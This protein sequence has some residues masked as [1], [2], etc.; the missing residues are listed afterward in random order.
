MVEAE[1]VEEGRLEVVH[2][3]GIL[4]DVEAHLVG[5]AEGHAGLDAAA[6]QPHRERLGVV[7]PAEAPA[8]CRIGLDHG[9][10]AELTAPDHQRVVEQPAPFQVLDQRRGG[11]I[12]GA[13]VRL[14][15]P[16]DVGVGVPALVID[17]HEPDAPLDHP[18][19]QQAGP[20]E[21]RLGRVG[22]VEIEGLLALLLEVHQLRGGRL[23]P[24]GHLVGGDP[25]GD[26]RV[27]RGVEMTTVQ[28]ADQVER[29]ALE[30]GVDAL[31]AGDVQDGI[32][33]VAEA[34]AGIDGRQEAAGPVGRAPADAAAG[35]HDHERGEFLRL[36]AEAVDDP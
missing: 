32:G 20:R 8:E 16:H 34:D 2:V 26:L 11:L 28:R 4:D 25:G 12:G 19:G 13:A 14:V 15:V 7:V 36:G 6:G 33:P 17:V 30:P 9:R 22:A 29:I 23:Q 18:P 1:Q 24:E 21:R 35:G 31:R 10:P 27:A 3:H 5:G